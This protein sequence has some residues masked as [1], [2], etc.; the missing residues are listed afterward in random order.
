[1]L[2]AAT[3]KKNA[4]VIGG[5]LLGLEAAEGL[6]KQGMDVTVVHLLDYLMEMQLDGAAANFLKMDLE[7]R[8]IKFE[9][10]AHT[11]AILGDDQVNGIR[12][13]DGREL[14]A[15]LVVVSVGI[16]PAISLAK[17]AGIKCE[18]GI[19]VNDFMQTTV[20]FICR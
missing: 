2:D 10:H 11:G 12:L 4:I 16:R 19:I 14:L 15:D 13:A 9:M 6:L 7:E 18:R 8:G 3:H 1:M 20:C 17:S 5:G